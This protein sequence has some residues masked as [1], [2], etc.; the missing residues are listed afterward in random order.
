MGESRDVNKHV[1]PTAL[2]TSEPASLIL[3]HL[4]YEQPCRV[5]LHVFKYLAPAQHWKPPPL[6]QPRDGRRVGIWRVLSIHPRECVAAA[7][8]RGPEGEAGV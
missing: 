1:E 8:D 5:C 6:L 3:Y 2:G 7:E 4:S